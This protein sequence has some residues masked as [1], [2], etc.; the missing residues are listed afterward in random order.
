MQK[1][2]K[3]KVMLAKSYA[4]EVDV[5]RESIDQSRQSI[6]TLCALYKTD[7]RDEYK[8]QE[9]ILSIQIDKDCRRMDSCLAL[10]S[11]L[12]GSDTDQS[13]ISEIIQ[14]S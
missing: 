3:H 6:M 9:A 2:N 1:F 4:D 5:L 14:Q 13:A 8:K 7:P 12:L 11:W 10:S